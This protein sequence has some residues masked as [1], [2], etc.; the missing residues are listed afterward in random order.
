MDFGTENKEKLLQAQQGA[1]VRECREMRG[2]TREELIE[3]IERLPENGSTTRS[4]KQLDYIER[5]VRPMSPQYSRLLSKALSVREQ[6]LLLEDNFATENDRI[7]HIAGQQF[8]R[9]SLIQ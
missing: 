7:S 9:S 1:R 4:A 6:Y 8:D 3:R 2:L 5:G